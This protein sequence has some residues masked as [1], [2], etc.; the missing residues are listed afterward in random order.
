MSLPPAQQDH[1]NTERV[2]CAACGEAWA[3][4]LLFQD[5]GRLI[6]GICRTREA[7]KQAHSAV[8]RR[9]DRFTWF[10]VAAIVVCL[11]AAVHSFTRKPQPLIPPLPSKVEGAAGVRAGKPVAEWPP[12]SWVE[13]NPTDWPPIVLTNSGEL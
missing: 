4:H 3:S 12:E 10:G 11:A 5:S 7:A 8:P 1:T 6:C 2:S 9:S 13:S